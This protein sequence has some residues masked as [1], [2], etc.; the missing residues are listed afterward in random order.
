M[1]TEWGMR[2]NLIHSALVLESEFSVAA[3]NESSVTV[4]YLVAL[5]S[6][7]ASVSTIFHTCFMTHCAA[8]VV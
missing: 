4:C 7:T 1:K 2:V 3:F 8:R 6:M 5:V